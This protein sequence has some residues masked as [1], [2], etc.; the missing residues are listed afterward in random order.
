MDS[1]RERPS[2]I[3]RLSRLPVPRPTSSIPKPSASVRPK[4]SRDSFI[5]VGGELHPPKLRGAPSREQLRSTASNSSLRGV[6]SRDQLRSSAHLTNKTDPAPRNCKAS[7][8]RRR[9]SSITIQPK[10]LDNNAQDVA[11]R[12]TFDQSPEQIR[13]PFSVGSLPLSA[14]ETNS[15]IEPGAVGYDAAVI[16]TPSI[17]KTRPRPSLSERTME[18]LANIPPS[19]ALKKKT[20]S[21]F[22]QSRPR[23]SAENGN[24]RP[25]SGHRSEG[26]GRASSRQGSSRP[27]S[28]AGPD[29]SAIAGFRGPNSPF[30]STLST[31]SGTPRRS[32]GI[33]V[34]QTPQPK[35]TPCRSVLSSI[36]QPS[37]GIHHLA[38]AARSPSPEK[39]AF[40]TMSVKPGPKATS[41]RP[42]KTRA[43]T[44][45]L[46]RPQ[47]QQT[48]SRVAGSSEEPEAPVTTWDGAIPAPPATP[49]HS[50]TAKPAPLSIRKSSAALREQIARA[51]AAKRAAV[52][53]TSAT[54]SSAIGDDT[55]APP[56]S[57]DLVVN[58]DDPFNLRK[59]E[60]A[61]VKVL[62]QR[63][64]AARTSGRLNI[65]A[66]GLKEMPSEV[67]K[68]YDLETI[69]SVNG[70]WAESVDLTRVV[71][72]DNEIGS[73]DDVFPDRS[74]DALDD[75]DEGQG[76]IF[77]GLET[78]DLHGNLLA[79][80]PL[81][82]RRLSLLTSL[83]LVSCGF[84]V[85]VPSVW[86]YLHRHS[87]RTS[88]RIA[89]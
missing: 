54:Q 47:P 62:Q 86:S 71:A 53:Q 16:R 34:T 58:H 82:F 70:S 10:I 51:K 8:F 57:G 74:P 25:G 15:D 19:P 76:N 52:R 2:G 75:Q 31:I 29:D 67:M 18:T 13:P 6:A 80:V 48:I 77:G 84:F 61:G 87:P 68:M 78:L 49:G 32:S 14:T 21:F 56:A 85:G 39:K 83:N 36:K 12:D 7:T 5:G 17:R 3:P 24:S 42:A 66:L 23:S 37:S 35:P 50:V 79:S 28:S 1:P 22:E 9:E 30:K 27:G 11:G 41:I 44:N 73:L 72:A 60:T 38:D 59:G 46:A 43:S 88:S 55:P 4:P 20:S 65:A 64:T 40:G 81:G 45:G 89:A 63:V 26:F 69:R 33:G